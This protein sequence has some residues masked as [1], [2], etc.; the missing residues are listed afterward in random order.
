MS[1]YAVTPCTC[2]R[3]RVIDLSSETSVCP[4]CGKSVVNNNV[5]KLFVDDDQRAVR[6]ALA[7]LTGFEMPEED[8]EVKK[9]IEEA[10]PFST[11]VYR[12]EECSDIELKMEILAKGLTELHGTFTLEDVKKVDKKNGERILKAMVV[13]CIVFEPEPGRYRI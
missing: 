2:G 10:D 9:R 11:L 5:R 7:Q 3:L 4:Y 6:D 1:G 12:Y 13:Q 8:P